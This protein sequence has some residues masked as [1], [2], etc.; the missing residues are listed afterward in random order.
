MNPIAIAAL[1]LLLSI[2][3]FM[4]AFILSVIS[5]IEVELFFFLCCRRSGGREVGYRISR[6]YGGGRSRA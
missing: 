4:S 2:L 1:V 6:I 5:D 3:S